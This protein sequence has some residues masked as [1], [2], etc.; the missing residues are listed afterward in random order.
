[1]QN[2]GWQVWL[3]L[4]ESNK[5]L[6]AAV[7]LSLLLH[8]L[9]YKGLQ[10]FPQESGS[11]ASVI[12]AILAPLPEKAMSRPKH[13]IVA[14]RETPEAEPLPLEKPVQKPETKPAKS[15]NEHE[16]IDETAMPTIEPVAQVVAEGQYS[17]G[18]AQIQEEALLQEYPEPGLPPVPQEEVLTAARGPAYVEMDYEVLKGINGSKLGE[19]FV[20][21]KANEDGTYFLTSETKPMGLA[22][23]FLPKSLL[24][25]SAGKITPMGLQPW[26][27][28]YELEDRPEKN[29]YAYFRWPENILLMKTVKGEKIEALPEGTQD[30]LSFMYQFMFSPPL[31]KM[32]LSLTNGKRLRTYEYLFAGEETVSTSVGELDVVHIVRE[33]VD[34][35]E[36]TELWLATGYRYLPVKIRKTEK[37]DHVVEQVLTRISADFL[38]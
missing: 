36:K 33:N 3:E 30:F 10:F 17:G 35:D 15:K 28:A 16:S 23:L 31:E 9:F 8:A 27:Y 25:R 22:S 26:E 13:A 20:R 7:F 14:A 6:S 2:K 32:Q 38:K 19:T 21:Y 12:R 1:M 18:E 11:H 37:G 34:G 24:I 5:R 29:Q 4:W